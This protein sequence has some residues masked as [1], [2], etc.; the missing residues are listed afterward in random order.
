[1]AANA[2]RETLTHAEATLK[3]ASEAADTSVTPVAAAPSVAPATPAASPTA[4]ADL[5]ALK[6]ARAAA[7][8][9]VKK[10][11]KALARASESGEGDI[12]DL[13]T[14]LATAQENMRAAEVRLTSAQPDGGGQMPER[15]PGQ[16]SEAPQGAEPTGGRGSMASN[17]TLSQA[18]IETARAENLAKRHKQVT[19]GAKAAEMAYHKAEAALTSADDES[20]AR[21]ETKLDRTR[22]NL[23]H[24]RESLAEVQALVDAQ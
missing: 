1:M 2:A 14:L 10:A 19:I 12:E 5:K 9:A 7:N 16:R 6:T 11:E 18:E 17:V 24:A 22:R 4:S 8:I 20:R 13:Q 15:I 3:S 23:E 21:L